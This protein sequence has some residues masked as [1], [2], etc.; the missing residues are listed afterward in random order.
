MN[1]LGKLSCFFLL[2]GIEGALVHAVY[3]HGVSQLTS[4]QLVQHQTLFTG[5]DHFA[6]VQ[7]GVFLPE[8]RLLGKLF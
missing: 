5:V 4:C 6:F 2:A 3:D 1:L 7:R 8:L